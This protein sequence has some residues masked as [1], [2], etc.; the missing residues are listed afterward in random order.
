[1]HLIAE[2]KKVG[3]KCIVCSK[4]DVTKCTINYS[5]KDFIWLTNDSI[6]CDEPKPFSLNIVSFTEVTLLNHN[7]IINIIGSGNS[8]DDIFDFLM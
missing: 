1:M 8:I 7:K 4:G 3:R 6:E 2:D 5:D